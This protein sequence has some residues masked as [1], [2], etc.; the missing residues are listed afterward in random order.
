[1][2]ILYHHR[3]LSK[4]GQNVHIEELISAF[5]RAGHE[6]CVI[7]PP[8]HG[9]AAF[10][11]DGGF[12]SKLRAALPRAVGET[13]ELLYSC[14]AFLRLWRAYRQFH[15]DV[16][17]ERYN[18][19]LLSGA[20]LRALTGLPFI[21]EVNSPLVLERSR[22]PGLALQRLARACERYVWRAADL[23]L[24]VT[25]VL[26]RHIR[27]AGVDERRIRIVMNGIDPAHFPMGL[28]G[29]GIRGRLGL[30]GK[31][32]IGFTGFLR[33]WHG[34]P[35]VIDVM[36][37]LIDRYD[38]HFL[39]VGDGPER[40]VL[41]EHARKRGLSDHLTVTGIVPRAEIPAHVA[42]FDI[43]L[44]PKATEYASPLKLF[45]YMALGCAILAPDQPNLKEVLDD[46]GNA[47]LFPRDDLAAFRDRLQRLI[48]DAGLRE[49]LGHAA[50][51]TIAARD[52][53]WSGNAR[54]VTSA[55][56]EL[57]AAAG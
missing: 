21:V 36:A 5:R 38:I 47:L 7:G 15:P 57:T 1:M 24:P 52:L 45:E 18:L 26:A 37:D 49:R 9:E 46:E 13:V 16:L 29:E 55:V 25:D 3:T 56:S 30:T 23:A 11:S 43:A 34:L 10:G 20:W 53:T 22:T 41:E 39:V 19:F 17:Y 14:A 32:V 54:R 44:Q 50:A 27:A 12:R 33:D 35:A 40:A 28:S 2:R 48:V 6:V 42:A 51:Q 4:D 8:G 31:V